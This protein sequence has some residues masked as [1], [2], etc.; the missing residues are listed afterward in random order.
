MTSPQSVSD[1]C[2]LARS[3]EFESKQICVDEQQISLDEDGGKFVG[4]TTLN[5]KSQ[6]KRG[7]GVGLTN[8]ITP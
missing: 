8:S 4:F 1:T 2:T 3:N 7:L 6:N 5:A